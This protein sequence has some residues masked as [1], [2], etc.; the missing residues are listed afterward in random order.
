MSFKYLNPGFPGLLDV[1]GGTLVTDESL[2]RTGVAFW[3]KDDSQGMNFSS[4]PKEIY[5]KFDFFL[6]YDKDSATDYEINVRTNYPSS[7]VSI[8]KTNTYTQLLSYVYGDRTYISSTAKETDFQEKTHLVRNQVNTIFFHVKTSS[9][10]DGVF[11]LYA[12]GTKIVSST[13]KISLQEPVVMVISSTKAV[14]PISGIILSDEP[15]DMRESILK[16]PTSGIE[17]DMK[18]NEDGSYTAS[19]EGQMWLQTVDAAALA[20]TYGSASK[21]TGIIS[22]ARPAYRTEDGLNRLMQIV[23]KGDTLTEYGSASVGKET[24]G[25]VMVTQNVDMTM[26]DLSGMKVGWKAGA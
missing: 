26:T 24:F 13:Q 10:S 19:A 11:E 2:S 17:T 12:N 5:C 4:L 6:Y 20:E 22:A 15:F 7:G 1:T 21:V 8:I 18:A 14:A 3:Q 25:A 9:Q 23:K 16:I